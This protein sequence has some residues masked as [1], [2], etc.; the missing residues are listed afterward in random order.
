MAAT[1]SMPASERIAGWLGRRSRRWWAG[2]VGSLVLLGAA[3]G[4]GAAMSGTGD[5]VRTVSADGWVEAPS[6]RVLAPASGTVRSLSV[7]DGD[8]VSAGQD[9]GWVQ[10]ALDGSLVP[11]RSPLAGRVS[12]V[13]STAGEFVVAGT[14]MATVHR[15]DQLYVRLEV[16]ER[17]IDS[18]APGQAIHVWLAAPGTEFETQVESVGRVP[19][20]G[21]GVRS[22]DEPKYEVRS[23]PLDLAGGVAP[24]MVAD[25]QIQ[26]PSR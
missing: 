6:A 24:G 13:S 1:T 20:A 19:I 17:D 22:R 2:V 15:L 8:D 4:T 21:D 5:D 7:A 3:A 14:P 23:A 26:I 18:V 12:D 25:G 11:L 16:G 10:S 9:I